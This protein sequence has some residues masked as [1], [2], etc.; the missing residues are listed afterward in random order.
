MQRGRRGLLPS[1]VVTINDENGNPCASISAQQQRWKRHFTQVLNVQSPFDPEE[2][3]KVRQRP[4]RADLA[5]KP[6]MRELTK[7]LGRLK[8]GKAA[9][10]SNILPE[11]IKTACD[12]EEFRALLLDL[13]HT[14]WEERQV[15]RE[16]ADA[17]LVPIPKKGNLR[18]CDNWRG[19]ALLDVVGK[20]VARII[21]ER[22]QQMAEVELPESQ[23]GFRKGR[24]CTDMIFTVRQ[25][26][27]K[28]IEHQARQ[29]FLFIDLKKAYDS[30]SR[31]AMW[32]ALEKLGVPDCVIS[33]IR[34]FHEGMCAKVRIGGESLEEIPVKNGLRQGCTMAPVLFN[35]YACLVAER[36]SARVKDDEDVEPT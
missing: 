10:S 36:W 4:L 8:N 17:I 1:V 14:V 28:A 2:L 32:C 18:N 34:S 9:G 24:G 15:P 19:I 33:I 12:D 16:W 29:F 25:L 23:C 7:A 26:V 20:V 35:L 30:V 5:E 6:S 31:K 27:E 21:Q 13:I 3:E 11:M 22:L